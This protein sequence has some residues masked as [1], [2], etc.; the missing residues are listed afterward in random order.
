MSRIAGRFRQLAQQ[1]RTALIPYIVAGD[2]GLD[3][4]VPLMH[5]LVEEGADIIELGVPFSDPM[6]EGPVIQLA[7]ER[8]LAHGTSLRSVLDLVAEFRQRDQKV[9]ECPVVKR[10]APRSAVGEPA[11]HAT[12]QAS[13]RQRRHQAARSRQYRPQRDEYLLIQAEFLNLKEPV[14][15]AVDQERCAGAGRDTGAAASIRSPCCTGMR[16]SEVP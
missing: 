15:V 2:P 5:R 4:T 3:S 13:L 11:V 10:I 1:G 12:A 7:H 8:S 14:R 16:R 6:S 9:R